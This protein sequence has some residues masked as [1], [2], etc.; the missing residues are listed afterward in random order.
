MNV[1]KPIQHN[2]DTVLKYGIFLTV[3]LCKMLLQSAMCTGLHF[4]TLNRETATTEVLKKVG[5][6]KEV[7]L[8]RRVLPWRSSSQEKDDRPGEL[9][10]PIFWSCRPGSYEHRT[11]NWE[12]FPNGRWGDSSSASFGNF[13]DYHLFFLKNKEMMC[14]QR[15]MWGEVLEKIE[16]VYDVFVAYLS[17]KDNRRGHKVTFYFFYSTCTMYILILFTIY[18]DIETFVITMLSGKIMVFLKYFL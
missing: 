5:L 7:K 1:L 4:F 16:D 12:T 9:V 10:R 6:W 18:G 14:E 15:K 8:G 3:E 13:R 2:D 17:G 11:S